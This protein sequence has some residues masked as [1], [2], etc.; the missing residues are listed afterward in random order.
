MDNNLLDKLR[1]IDL[2][3]LTDVVRQDQRDP[4]FEITNWTVK[5]LSDKGIAN[6]DGLWLFSGEGTRGN[7]GS[8]SWSIVLKILNRPSEE[9]TADNVWYWKREFSFAQSS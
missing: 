6:P 1:T 5:R 7:S 2:D 8:A 9:L 4:S 3:I